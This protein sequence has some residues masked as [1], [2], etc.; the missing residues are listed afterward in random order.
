MERKLQLD[1]SKAVCAYE[2]MLRYADVFFTKAARCKNIEDK[3]TLAVDFV[4][5]IKRCFTKHWQHLDEQQREKVTDLWITLGFYKHPKK[6]STREFDLGIDLIYFQ[7]YYGGRLVDVQSDPKVD[8]R[9]T[10]FKPDAWQR[11]ML[12]V[13][14]QCAFGFKRSQSFQ[15]CL[16]TIFRSVGADCRANVS[17]QNVRLILLHR[18]GSSPKQ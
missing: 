6:K 8:D 17:G 14:D 10:G 2:L 18:E 15:F 11:E 12:N 16:F 4:S 13:V 9:V 1:E 3:R 5:H 7:L